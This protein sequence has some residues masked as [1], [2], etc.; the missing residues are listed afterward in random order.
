M[1]PGATSSKSRQ[2]NKSLLSSPQL[3]LGDTIPL[4][5]EELELELE[6]ELEELL[7]ITA[8]L[9]LDDVLLALFPLTGV[10]M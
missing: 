2:I 6:L 3:L 9:E 5:L 10:P 4:E 7:I 8:P 1:P